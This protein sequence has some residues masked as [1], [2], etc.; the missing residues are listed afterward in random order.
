MEPS[1]LPFSPPDSGRARSIA[2]SPPGG[3]EP[4]RRPRGRDLP[5]RSGR[6]RATG[7]APPLALRSRPPGAL[8]TGDT[9]S[10]RDVLLPFLEV[11]P[12]GP[13]R[14]L[15]RRGVPAEPLRCGSTRRTNFAE[16]RTPLR[17]IAV[18][19][20]RG[21]TVAF[22]DRKHRTVTIS[23]AVQASTALPGLYRPV[24]L[25][26]KD[27]IDGGVTKTAHINLAIRRGADLVICIN[28]LVPILNGAAKSSL[29]PLV[30]SRRRYR[31]RARCSASSFM[32]G[33]S[34]AWNGIAPS[35]PRSTFFSSS[36][37]ATISPCSA[38]TSCGT[39]R[40]R[41]SPATAVC[42][43]SRTC[44]T[45]RENSR[46]PWPGMGCGSRTV[47]WSLLSTRGMRRNTRPKAPSPSP[48][49]STCSSALWRPR[50]QR[51]VMSAQRAKSFS[52]SA[53]LVNRHKRS[54]RSA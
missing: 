46:P 19:L 30:Q 25:K 5:A 32:A 27:Y 36:P 17:I 33:S 23:E 52:S 12:P 18:D 8:F 11:I 31:A 10:P 21:E 54:F 24:R 47:P 44:A 53:S 6:V 40:A 50:A 48:P 43:P 20:D 26:G 49:R 42:R 45:T 29:G 35:I 37:P 4:I 51:E 1:W 34:T 16:L 3:G 15:G 41:P 39:A 2:R 28:P 22:G 7:P 14:Q 9:A 13:S 38:T